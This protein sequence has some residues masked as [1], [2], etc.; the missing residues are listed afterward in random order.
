MGA[1]VDGK[2]HQQTLWEEA[3]YPEIAYRVLDYVERE[4]KIA[5]FQN[6]RLSK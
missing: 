6:S 1:V 2:S 3:R 5:G 4:F